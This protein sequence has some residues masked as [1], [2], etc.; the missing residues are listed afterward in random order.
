M[1]EALRTA[2]VT[3]EVLTPYKFHVSE[4]IYTSIVLHSDREREWKSYQHPY[5]ESKMLSPQDLL[6]WTI[7]RYKL[8]RRQ[9]GHPVP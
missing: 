7:Q 2:A 9:P 5:V 8:R 6:T 3:E 4:D 1:L